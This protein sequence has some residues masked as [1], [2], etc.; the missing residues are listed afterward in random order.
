MNSKI[1][2]LSIFIGIL[3]V[4]AMVKEYQESV[5]QWIHVM[6]VFPSPSPS[7]L[8]IHAHVHTEWIYHLYVTSVTS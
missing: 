4:S 7:F 6:M 2:V 1:A 8:H 5:D 3:G